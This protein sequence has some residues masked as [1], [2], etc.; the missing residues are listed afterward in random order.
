M[1]CTYLKTAFLCQSPH[2]T[3]DYERSLAVDMPVRVS[4]RDCLAEA[5]QDV[6]TC[7]NFKDD[8]KVGFFVVY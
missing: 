4:L 5:H 1:V 7:W 3:S 8:A 2:H 6:T